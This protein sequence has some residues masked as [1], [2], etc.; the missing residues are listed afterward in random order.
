MRDL[1][2]DFQNAFEAYND[3]LFRHASMRLKDRERALE[4][5]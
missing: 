1:Q 2:K 4:L 5:T 3:E